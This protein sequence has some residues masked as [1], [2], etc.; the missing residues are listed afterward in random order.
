MP[1]LLQPRRLMTVTSMVRP[2]SPTHGH[3][4]CTTGNQLVKSACGSGKVWC[5]THSRR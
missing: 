3:D 4:V 5:A 2:F 1:T